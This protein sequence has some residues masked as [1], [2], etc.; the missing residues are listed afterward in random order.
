MIVIILPAYEVGN[1]TTNVLLGCREMLDD[2]F[3]LFIN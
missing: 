2:E 3:R 1:N